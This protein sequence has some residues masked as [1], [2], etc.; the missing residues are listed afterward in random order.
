MMSSINLFR[1]KFM[2]MSTKRSYFAYSILQFAED[3]LEYPEQGNVFSK[4]KTQG[5]IKIIK[6]D[7]SLASTAVTNN[8][9][10]LI[11]TGI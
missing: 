5:A 4:F 11:K 1:K 10:S 8:I 9:F 3:V 7:L 2:E 6:W